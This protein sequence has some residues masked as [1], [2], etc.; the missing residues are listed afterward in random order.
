MAKAFKI[1]LAFIAG[2]VVTWGATVAAGVGYM[3]Y[4]KI[5]DRDGGGAMGLIFIIGPFCGVIGGMIAAVIT[6]RK[7]R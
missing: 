2:L 1:I 5:F 4:F 6:A 3:N 7:L